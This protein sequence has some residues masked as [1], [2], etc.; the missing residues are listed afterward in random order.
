[1]AGHGAERRKHKRHDL[2]CPIRLFSRGGTQVA[3]SKTIN[4]S[5]SGAFV[6][7]PLNFLPQA[8]EP[9]NVAI[10]V[11]RSTAN[12]YMLEDFACR[13]TVT[14]HQPVTDKDQMGVALC[15]VAPLNLAIEV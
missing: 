14:R 11:P 12:T 15:F 7:L 6:P 1:M 13:A 4:I 8:T 5:D 2:R 3:G 10:S 9:L